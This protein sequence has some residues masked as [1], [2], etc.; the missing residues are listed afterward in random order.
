MTPSGIEPATFRVVAQWLNQLRH[1][2]P[3]LNCYYR[4]SDSIIE[5]SYKPMS[6]QPGS[7]LYR[8]R[9]C[10]SVRMVKPYL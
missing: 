6:Q 7:D 8:D 9:Q 5:V 4:I 1:N 10:L 3:Q 2:V